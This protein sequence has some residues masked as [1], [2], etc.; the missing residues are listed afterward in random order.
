LPTETQAIAKMC[1]TVICGSQPV[2]VIVRGAPNNTPAALR[3]VQAWPVHEDGWKRE[4]IRAEV[5]E[6][7]D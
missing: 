4:I 3:L 2:H 5:E 6:G 1:V 7:A